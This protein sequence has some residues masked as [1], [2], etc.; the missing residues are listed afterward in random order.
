M[1]ATTTTRIYEIAELAAGSETGRRPRRRPLR[2]WLVASDN[3][4]Q[5]REL[6]KR[7]YPLSD[8]DLWHAL[9]CKESLPWETVD[10][11][12]RLGIQVLGADAGESA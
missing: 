6:V 4:V 8:A 5:A 11:L 7:E 3:P 10:H 12:V 2:H 9:R 1:T